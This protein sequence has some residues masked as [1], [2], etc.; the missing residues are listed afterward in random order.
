MADAPRQSIINELGFVTREDVVNTHN[1][2][3]IDLDQAVW[4]EGERWPSR[5]AVL[6]WAESYKYRLLKRARHNL[7]QHLERN[8]VLKE[9]LRQERD[10]EAAEKNKTSYQERTRLGRQWSQGGG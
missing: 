10:E 1:E 4:P 8:P 3:V 2:W 6:E 9:K 7:D 5:A